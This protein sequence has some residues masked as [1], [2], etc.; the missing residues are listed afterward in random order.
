MVRSMAGVV[1]GGSVT[2]SLFMSDCSSVN[3]NT[4]LCLLNFLIVFLELVRI[5]PVVVVDSWVVDVVGVVGVV[6]VN[7]GLLLLRVGF[8]S[9][10]GIRWIIQVGETTSGGPEL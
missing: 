5:F 9:G 7:K 6:V 4:L 3:F 2:K 8:C 1:V 10:S